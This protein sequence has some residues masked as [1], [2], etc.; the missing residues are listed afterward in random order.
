MNS[1]DAL[2]QAD[3]N[4][5]NSLNSVIS[6]VAGNSPLKDIP[7][8]YSPENC[9]QWFAIPQGV[10]AGKKLFFYDVV[11]GEGSP[12]ATIVCVHGNPECSYSYRHVAQQLRIN[13]KQCYRLIVMDHIGFG[14]S[15]QASFEMVDKH[16]AQNLQQLIIYLDLQQVTLVIHDW[17]GPIG[18]GAFID[19]PERV[20][21]LIVLNTTVF[22]IPR[23]GSTYENFPFPIKLLSWAASGKNI[24]D[25]LWPTHAA[26]A[27]HAEPNTLLPTLGSYMAYFLKSFM[28][29]LP[30]TH[31]VYKDMFGTKENAKSSKRMVQQTPVWGHGYQ[32]QDPVMGLQD[33]HGFYDNIQNNISRQWGPE[34][35]NIQV[36]LLFGSWDPLAKESVIDQWLEALPQLKGHVHLFK[37]TSHFVAE[38]KSVEISQA[39]IEVA[40][41]G[42]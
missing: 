10:D 3:T 18:I 36:R 25:G 22:P 29:A 8:D 23:S 35:K 37:N 30:A 20:A 39:I 17:G 34:G 38:H 26:Y 24:P 28:G 1:T 4:K 21:H 7:E 42:Q 13:S 5:P 14:R 19:E 31:K 41:L 33:N 2:T 32:Y 16:H 6:Q 11:I 9:G 40:G 12:Q 15:D 27:V